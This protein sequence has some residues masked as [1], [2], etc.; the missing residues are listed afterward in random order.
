MSTIKN[1]TT[2]KRL[3]ALA[4]DRGMQVWQLRS[5]KNFPAMI[6]HDTVK[7]ECLAYIDSAYPTIRIL[8][9]EWQ[10]SELVVH[11]PSGFAD[12]YVAFIEKRVEDNIYV[13]V[14]NLHDSLYYKTDVDKFLETK[15][16]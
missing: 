5:D 3:S 16:F 15:G 6:H 10:P 4:A 11:D 8:G 2:E 7:A 9:C 12:L 14:G 13:R 1:M